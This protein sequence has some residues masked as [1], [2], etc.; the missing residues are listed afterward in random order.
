MKEKKKGAGEDSPSLLFVGEK[1]TAVGVFDGMGGAG[2]KLCKD[3]NGDIHSMAYVASRIIEN[4]VKDF[5]EGIQDPATLSPASFKKVIAARFKQEMENHPT[6]GSLLR[7]DLVRDYPTTMAL[8]VTYP[9]NESG[10]TVASY[11]AGDS[12]A[13]LWTKDGLT[14][15]S[16]DDLDGNLDPFENLS[17]DARMTNCLCANKDFFIHEIKIKSIEGP[18][19]IFSATDGCFGYL[20]TPMHFQKVLQDTLQNSLNS[21]NWSGKLEAA[22]SA[23]TGDDISFSLAAIGF[24]NFDALKTALTEKQI[25]LQDK[26]GIQEKI[27]SLENDINAKQKE[28]EECL[29]VLQRVEEK[30]ANRQKKISENGSYMNQIRQEIEEYERQREE[31]LRQIKLRRNDIEKI[32]TENKFLEQ[33]I[34]KIQLDCE[35]IRKKAKEI[36]SEKNNLKQAQQQLSA[37]RSEEYKIIWEQYKANYMKHLKEETK[38]E[39]VKS[40]TPIPEA[41][42]DEVKV[43]APTPEPKIDEVKVVAPTPEPKIDEAKIA[44]PMPEKKNYPYPNSDEDIGSPKQVA[45]QSFL[46]RL[47]EAIMRLFK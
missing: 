22:F 15:I 3:D 18:F 16:Q 28:Q 37:K 33:E 11:W 14:Q 46:H 5:L 31:I 45:S 43:V 17:N 23:V 6:K 10:Y 24:E 19:A 34:E 30:A 7:S 12:R 47:F 39:E 27:N 38:I 20:P 40:A 29:Q 13:F 26:G 8:A 42:T 21:E 32:Y 2:G 4:S 9:E 44:S 36:E 35:P 1:I 25:D 41:K